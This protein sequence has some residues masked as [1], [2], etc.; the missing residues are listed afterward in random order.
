MKRYLTFGFVMVCAGVLCS[1]PSF[2]E[3]V[4]PQADGTVL[5]SNGWKLKPA[6]TQVPLD[7]LPMSTALS[8]RREIPAGVERRVQAAVDQRADCEFAARNFA[9]A[10]GGCMAGAHI[11]AG[12]TAR[13][14][15]RRIE[16]HVFEFSFS[17]E[18]VLEPERE[19][20]VAAADKRTH[21]D[22]IGDVAVSPDGK[23]I[24]AAEILSRLDRGDQCA[25]RRHDTLQDWTAALPDSVSSR[26]KS[27]LRIQLERWIGL[28]SRRAHGVEMSRIRI[29]PHPTDMTLS[30]FKPEGTGKDIEYRLF[31]AAANTNNVFVVGVGE[32]RK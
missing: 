3:Q 2:R 16:G 13:V 14:C 24:Y 30:D 7:T 27:V 31:V 15:R 26:R 12:R 8:K 11:F 17:P 19:F 25:V 20:V 10:G 5:L 29:G 28:S 18:G 9:S 22:F 21:E 23:L 4:G 6:G 32:P 1:Q